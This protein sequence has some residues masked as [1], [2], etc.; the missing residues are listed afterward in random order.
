MWSLTCT[1]LDLI[2]KQ[3]A[4]TSRGVLTQKPSWLLRV[5]NAAYPLVTGI[6]E[7]SIIPG[8]S[9]DDRPELPHKL[10]EV[11]RHVNAGNDIDWDSLADW[12]SIRF[13]L[14]TALL[15]LNNGGTRTL[16]PSAFVEGYE[17]IPINGLIWMGDVDFMSRQIEKK[18]SEG[19]SC[20]KMKIGAIGFDDELALLK[21][22][23]SRFSPDVLELRVDAN[24]AFGAKDVWSRL[25]AL[26]KLDLHSIEQP[27]KAGQWELMREVC[28]FSPVPVALDEELIGA[29]DAVKMQQMLSSIRPRYIILKPG[30]LGGFAVCDSWIALASEMGV[31]WWATSA[32]ESNIGLNAIA[33]YTFTKQV[34]MPQGLGTGLLYTN[35]IESPLQ[36]KAGKLYY[37]TNVA[38]GI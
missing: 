23:R 14:E 1:K 19:F 35:N 26:A 37:H 3:P 38:W 20:L 6:G 33:Q 11:A 13:G 9:H 12:P 21:G 18:L 4:G 16:F 34:T 29:W 28:R 22:V 25:D 32:L 36:I 30:L 24:G 15:D 31:G 17:G 7:V 27:V 2:F 5:N 10:D 8:L